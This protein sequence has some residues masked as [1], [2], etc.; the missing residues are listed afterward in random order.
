MHTSDNRFTEDKAAIDQTRRDVALKTASASLI[1]KLSADKVWFVKR[2]ISASHSTRCTGSLSAKQ[3]LGFFL[4]MLFAAQF[5]CEA[6][7]QCS[8]TP[9]NAPVTVDD[10]TAT[11]P[12][13]AQLSDG[14]GTVIDTSTAGQIKVDLPSSGVTAGSYTN[15]NITVNAQGVVTAAANGTGGGGGGGTVTSVNAGTETTI[16]GTSTDPT[17]NVQFAINSTLTA[18]TTLTV[19]KIFPCDTSSGAFSLTLPDA[20]ATANQ[21]A[22]IVVFLKAAGNNLSIS[23]TSSQLINGQSGG[24]TVSKVNSLLEFMS[25]GTNWQCVP[26]QPATSQ[27]TNQWLTYIDSLG[28]QHTAQPAFSNLSGSV[29]GAQMPTL[30]SGQIYVGNASGVPTA[31]SPTAGAGLSVSAGSGSL[32]YS[33]SSPVSI[34]NGGT[35]STTSPTAGQLLIGTT[36]GGFSTATPTAGTGLSVSAGSGSLQYSLSS[37]VSIANGGTGSTT[38]PTAGQLLVGTTGGGFSTATPTAGTGLSVSAGSGSLQYSLSTPVSIANG[39]TGTTTAPANG[40]LLIGNS[41]GGYSVAN[42]TAGSNVTI[43]NSSGGI[44]IASSASGSGG[45]TESSKSASFTAAVANCYEVTATATCTLPTAASNAGQEIMVWFNAAS[46]TL[47]FNTTSSQTMSGIASGSLTTSTRYD[48]Y[49]FVSNGS[50]WII[51]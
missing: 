37:P 30:S 31:T 13:S 6:L 42:L 28:V 4:T 48:L 17:V 9:V 27:T 41:S 24:M 7:A 29:T 5:N 40:K 38:A 12:N 32:Q 44:S 14:T 36:G 23:T 19:G 22:H 33:L 47:T 39:G 51:E 1:E 21:G 34:A 50:N 11:L 8:G 46:G 43:T 45:F 25:D 35:G 18:N 2:K 26:L 16:G 20:S 10:E 3:L 15:S 49:R